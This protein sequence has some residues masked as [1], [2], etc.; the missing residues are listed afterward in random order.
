MTS[1]GSRSSARTRRTT[2]TTRASR[3]STATAARRTA[4]GDGVA[5]RAALGAL[6]AR[7]WTSRR[8]CRPGRAS[9]SR[10]R[11]T[12]MTT[13]ARGRRRPPPY[14]LAILFNFACAGHLELLPID[15]SSDNPQQVP[16]GCFD[17]EREPA[18]PGRLRLRLHARL[19]VRSDV[20]TA[21]S[22]TRTPSS[23]RRR[24]GPDARRHARAR[25]RRRST[26][27]TAITTPAL[28]RQVASARHRPSARRPRVEL[29]A[30]PEDIGVN[31]KPL[32]EEIW[33]DY[34]TTLRQLLGRREP[35][36]RRRPG[37][38]RRTERHRRQLP[39]RR[40]T[41]GTGPSGSWSTTTGAARPG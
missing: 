20:P 3:S 28:Q 19:R 33:A 5:A 18:R 31:G 16:L 7:A 13:H 32:H 17:A 6:A 10:C 22:P 14:G 35:A 37:L 30:E 8:S 1:T 23:T 25:R 24:P 9:S 4:G 41:P 15:P 29:G 34:Y 36:L 11:P 38:D 12:S 2:R 27:R 26:R 40:P 21:S 39:G